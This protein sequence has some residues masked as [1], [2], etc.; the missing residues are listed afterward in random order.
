MRVRRFSPPVAGAA[1]RSCRR[2]VR[3]RAGYALLPTA[4][5][6]GYSRSFLAD[7]VIFISLVVFH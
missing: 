4:E 1:T 6:R 5:R 2:L 3:I 7:D